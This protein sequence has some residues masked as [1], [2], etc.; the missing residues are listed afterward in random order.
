MSKKT[1]NYRSDVEKQLSQTLYLYSGDEPDSL[2]FLYDL[3]MA[4]GAIQYIVRTTSEQSVKYYL[5][6]TYGT[7]Q[8]RDICH[9]VTEVEVAEW[10]PVKSRPRVSTFIVRFKD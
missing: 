5:V 10:P 9:D 7:Q 8:S 6:R 2:D 3:S 1:K 4:D